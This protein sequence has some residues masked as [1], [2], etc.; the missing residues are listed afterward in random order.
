M[1]AK[2]KI[3]FITTIKITKKYSTFVPNSTSH[4]SHSNS[5]PGLVFD[6]YRVNFI[7]PDY[8][9]QQVTHYNN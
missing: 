3:N 1:T 2:K 5:A 8:E 4:A 7:Q 9:I 6:F